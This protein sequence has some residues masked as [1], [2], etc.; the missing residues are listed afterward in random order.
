[1]ETAISDA[2]HIAM[3][4]K[5]VRSDK[6]L[7]RFNGKY[8]EECNSLAVD[9]LKRSLNELA[10]RKLA[11]H[12]VN[13]AYQ[14]FFS[15]TFRACR[16]GLTFTP[17]LADRVNFLNGTPFTFGFWPKTRAEMDTEPGTTNHF[18]AEFR[19]HDPKDYLTGMGYQWTIGRMPNSGKTPSLRRCLGGSGPPPMGSKKRKSRCIKNS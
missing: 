11:S 18:K 6:I 19:P 16:R 12:D 8:W 10:G 3:R 9:A 17:H 15:E 7:F 1:M 4:G 5:L 13:S 2:L 14:T